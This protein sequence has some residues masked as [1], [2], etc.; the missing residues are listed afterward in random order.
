MILEVILVMVAVMAFL[1]IV[2]GSWIIGIYNWGKTF[3]QDLKT[4][5]SNIK[6]EYQR[7]ADLFYNLASSIKSH[8]KFEKE[9]LTA[10]IEAR[11][12]G[13]TGT[14]PQQKKQMKNLDASFAKLLAV[15]EQ[16]PNLKSAGLYEKFM[17]ECRITEDRVNIARTSY[18][19]IVREYN[20]GITVFP[21]NLVAGQF[22][23]REEDYFKND[24]YSEEAK[25]FR[26]ELD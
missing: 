24:S 12:K 10:V 5:W 9:T 19:D 17:E 20:T 22:G 11:T 16:Y 7:R 13:F 4:Q 15:F 3:R 26:V 1:V 21:R 8:K 14:V 25:S 18:N 23:F 6:T 2:S